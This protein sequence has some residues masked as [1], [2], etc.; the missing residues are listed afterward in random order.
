MLCLSKK[1]LIDGVQYFSKKTISG[2]YCATCRKTIRSKNSYY[3]SNDPDKLICNL[4]YCK[5]TLNHKKAQMQ[6]IMTIDTDTVVFVGVKAKHVCDNA[7]EAQSDAY[8]KFFLE[9]GNNDLILPIKICK[10]CGRITL[11]GKHYEK[12]KFHLKNYTFINAR[13]GKPQL[14]L[15]VSENYCPH[16]SSAVKREIPNS[17]SW[18]VTHPFQGG[19]CSGK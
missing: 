4:C 8:G 15:K 6:D 5:I 13:T 11:S 14:E 2:T 18:A 16:F 3:S 12:H 1:A 17:V 10:N 19:K 9:D 7:D